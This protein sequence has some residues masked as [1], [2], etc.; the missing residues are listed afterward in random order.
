MILLAVKDL[1]H[2]IC[3][4]QFLSTSLAVPHINNSLYAAHLVKTHKDS[5]VHLM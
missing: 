5:V 3:T 4:L 2:L 1:I